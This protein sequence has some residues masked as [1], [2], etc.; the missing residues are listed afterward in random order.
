[1]VYLI[2]NFIEFF[3]FYRR[4]QNSR[5]P[6]SIRRTKARNLQKLY[7]KTQNCF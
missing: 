2:P 5:W 6:I 7:W 4:D 3:K 1:M